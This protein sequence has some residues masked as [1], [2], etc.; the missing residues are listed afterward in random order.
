[1]LNHSRVRDIQE[2]YKKNPQIKENKLQARKGTNPSG[3]IAAKF[4]VVSARISISSIFINFRRNFR[5]TKFSGKY[6][7]KSWSY[8]IYIP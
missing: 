4:L 1:M 7:L 5:L 8:Y 6:M 2:G 3:L